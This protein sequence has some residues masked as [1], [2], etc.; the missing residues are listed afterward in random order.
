MDIRTDGD[1]WAVD[2]PTPDQV[3]AV[4]SKLGWSAQK[5]ANFV[6]ISQQTWSQYDRG[7]T[8]M[9]VGLWNL[10]LV[11]SGELRPTVKDIPIV[12]QLDMA[13]RPKA[14]DVVK[15]RGHETMEQVGGRFGVSKQQ[16]WQWENGKANIKP[17]QF[18]YFALR[19]GKLREFPHLFGEW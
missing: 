7:V 2:A 16:W 17:W 10:F 11:K 14:E 19:L 12:R 3:K 15:L 9:P 8:G 13:F 18:Q 4:R 6:H 5:S 1:G